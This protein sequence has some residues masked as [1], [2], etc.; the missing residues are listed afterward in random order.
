MYGGGG[1]L[2]LETC[3]VTYYIKLLLII[4][5]QYALNTAQYAAR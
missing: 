4:S 3:N 5:R 1:M 2:L